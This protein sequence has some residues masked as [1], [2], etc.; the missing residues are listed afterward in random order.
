[1]NVKSRRWEEALERQQKGKLP[2][3]RAAKTKD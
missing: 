2:V 3:P 1:M